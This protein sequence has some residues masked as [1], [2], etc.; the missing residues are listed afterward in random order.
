MA[1]AEHIVITVHGI[2]TFGDWQRRFELLVNA[3]SP[4]TQF[5]HFQYGYF[6]ILAF[7][8]PFTR[9]LMVK[10]FKRELIELVRKKQPTRVDCVGHS[11]GTHII[12]WALRRLAPSDP[13]AINTVILAGSVLRSSFYWPELIPSRVARVI[14]DCGAKDV[15]LLASQFLVPLT[16]MAG[17]SGFVGMNGPEFTNRYSMF[18]HSGYFRDESGNNCDNYMLTNWVPL[19]NG[20]DAV[21]SFDGRGSPTAWRGLVLWITNNFEPI[22]IAI[23]ISPFLAAFIGISALYLEA[24]ATNKRLLAVNDLGKA[25]RSQGRSISPES[26]KILT[27]LQRAVTLPFRRQFVLWVDDNPENNT[28]EEAALRGF[29]LCFDRATN[30]DDALKLLEAGKNKYAILI[31][32]FTRPADPKGGYGLIDEL[33]KKGHE[34]PL[35]YYTIN[36]SEAQVADAR[37]R[38]AKAE[39]ELPFDL[40]SEIFDAL[41]PTSAPLGRIELILQELSGCG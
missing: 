33:K 32:D 8:I 29:G 11:F 35:L 28:F 37:S 15:V 24:N 16:G 38:G 18:G 26:E 20:D 7:I 36:V 12:S 23:L 41:N 22:K 6:S 13:I 25:A 10:R 4:D 27:T 17:R 39:V 5:Y 1:K 19:I 30:T 21:T 34:I 31:S 40:Y 9:W 2:R 3:D 14:N